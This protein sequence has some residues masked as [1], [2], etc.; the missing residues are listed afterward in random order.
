MQSKQTALYN[1]HVA[2]GAK[3]VP[4]AGFIMPVQ[5]SGIIDEHTTV[6]NKV[7]VF[8]VSHMGEFEFRGADAEKFL[9]HITTNNV[10]RLDPGSIHYSAMLYDDGGVVDDL[11]VYRF[12]DHFMTVVNA[13]NLDKDFK[14]MKSHLE[15]DVEMK[16]VS[17]QTTLLAIQGPDAVSLLKKITE[18][19]LDEIAYYNFRLGRVA[20]VNAV[21]SRTGYTG[22]DGFELYVDRG[23]SERLWDAVFE[24]GKEFGVKPIGLGAR[25]SLRLEV[26]FNL[27][28]ND[29]DQTTNPIEAGLGWIV[30]SKKRGGFIGKQ[31]V[32]D[33]K[34]KTTR[35]LI[36]FVLNQ[37]GIARHNSE[38]YH[39]NKK[40]GHVTSGGFS[41]MLNKPIG[42]GYV[43]KPYH[44]F[45]TM[46]EIDL[47][48]RRLQA[49]IVQTPFYK[50]P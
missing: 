8:D 36:G 18:A 45:G 11:L 44:K 48:G 20:G 1:N 7:G 3:M 22:E 9:N 49:E 37:K 26:C 15:G 21:I 16:D 27:Y 31:P 2:L 17:D 29:M 24:A 12:E 5:Y 30:K 4:F 32:L 38:L 47:R 39:E 40:I 50:R 46:I 6:R 35:K 34:A 28:G 13:A 33:A 41:P 23:D 14:W 10:A 19:P 25:D 43:D 42:L